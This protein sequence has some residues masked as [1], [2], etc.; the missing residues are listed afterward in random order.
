MKIVIIGCGSIGSRHARNLH[1]LR[2]GE[3][4]LVDA[5]NGRAEQLAGEIHA[6]SF[7]CIERA[8]DARPE[9][10][11]I[12]APTSLHLSLAFQAL[13][14]G[15]HLFVEKPLADAMKG[16]QRLIDLAEVR[17]RVLLAGYNFRFDP[18]V[19]QVHQWIRQQKIGRVTSARFHFGSYLPWRHPEEDYRCGYGARRDL[20]GGIILDAVHELDMALWLFGFPQTVYTVGGRYSDL[21]IDTEDTAEI[22]MSYPD[23]VVSMHLDYIQ[24]PAERWCE[25]IGTKG[26]IRAD[27]FARTA[28]CFDGD[29]RIWEQSVANGSL[30]ETYKEEMR[31]LLECVAG[32]A[33]P[34]V[35]GRSAAASLMLAEDARTSMRTGLAVPFVEVATKACAL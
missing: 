32:R 7:D 14:R 11:L 27:L 3:L 21:E 26:Q 6:K 29:R 33:T 17:K 20:G 31:H 18:V 1:E 2:A 4:L 24:R 22:V 16:V 35:D 5:D 9:L 10:A 25:I 13:E 8:Y 15:C 34:A 28:K 12:C 19:S 23:K 30:E